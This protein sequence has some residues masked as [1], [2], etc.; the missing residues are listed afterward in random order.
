M[1]ERVVKFVLGIA[2]PFLFFGYLSA[3]VSLLRSF[4]LENPICLMFALGG[5]IA[6]VMWSLFLKRKDFYATFSHEFTH[7]L[8]GLLTFHSPRALVVTDGAGGLVVIGGNFLVLLAPY[9]F[10]IISYFVLPILL[11]VKPQ[12]YPGMAGIIGF[13]LVYHFLVQLKDFRFYQSDIKKAG[14]LFSLVFVPFAMVLSYGFVVAVVFYGFSK[15]G[16]FLK[17]GILIC[18]HF[19]TSLI[20]GGVR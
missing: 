15:G 11:L 9:F 2:S 14:I 19:F 7:L 13:T 5:G 4:T 20:Q 16:W 12:F 8:F 6:F 17:E 10:P 18:L 1:M 3:L